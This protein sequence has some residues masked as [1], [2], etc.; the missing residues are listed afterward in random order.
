[1]GRRRYGYPEMSSRFICIKC[2]KE[3]C[4]GQGIQRGRMREREHIKDL[5][6]INKGCNNEITK[7]LEVRFCDNYL[8]LLPKAIELHKLY[9]IDNNIE[10][11]VINMPDEFL[12][13][14]EDNIVERYII[15]LKEL[16]VE[17]GKLDMFDLI[18]E[19][20]ET[21]DKLYQ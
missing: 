14:T 2:L 19:A 10:K 3:N 7:N 5:T 1:M 16:C 12:K 9:Y 17:Q 13:S 11:D 18:D 21:Y 6:C 15:K 8:D 20:K 4:V